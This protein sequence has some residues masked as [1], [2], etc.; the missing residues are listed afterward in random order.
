MDFWGDHKILGGTTLVR[1]TLFYVVSLNPPCALMVLRICVSLFLSLL[2]G[3]PLMN[4]QVFLSTSNSWAF[5]FVV[6]IVQYDLY[7]SLVC[8][9]DN[10]GFILPYFL[11]SLS[12][13]PADVGSRGH[14][15]LRRRLVSVLY[16]ALHIKNAINKCISNASCMAKLPWKVYT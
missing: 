6:P 14:S 15:L 1:L 16:S 10:P 5:F 8:C 13:L 7:H 9:K 3:S 12:L 4:L 2:V 11:E